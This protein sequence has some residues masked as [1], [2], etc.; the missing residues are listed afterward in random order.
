MRLLAA[1]VGSAAATALGIIL[2][3]QLPKRRTK[4]L[5]AH[6]WNDVHEH[7]HQAALK[8]SVDASLIDLSVFGDACPLDVEVLVLPGAVFPEAFDSTVAALPA[9]KAIIIPYAG[10]MAKHLDRLEAA[11]GDRLDV[12]IAVHNLARRE[13]ESIAPL[14]LPCS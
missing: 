7:D 1:A 9:L 2:I 4:R 14:Q 10:L 6:V 8:E 5:R 3:C 12:E 13:L 11:L